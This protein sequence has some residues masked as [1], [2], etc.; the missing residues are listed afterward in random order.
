M[1]R[2]GGG[3]VVVVDSKYPFGDTATISVTAPKA[4]TGLIRIPGWA[5]AATVD[6]VKVANGTMHT[7]V[8]PAGTT[9]KFLVELNPEIRV[10]YGWGE[11]R[12]SLCSHGCCVLSV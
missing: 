7:V 4:T 2:V 6:G 10:E 5:S 3:A 12:C 1:D 9:Q 11:V 8:C